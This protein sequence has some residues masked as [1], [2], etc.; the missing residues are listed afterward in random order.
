MTKGF[1]RADHA[2]FVIHDGKIHL[3]EIKTGD[4]PLSPA[5]AKFYPRVPGGDVRIGSSQLADL[6]LPKGHVLK[7]GEI[8]SVRVERWDIDSMPKQLR[9][10]VEDH[11]VFD[12]LDGKAGSGAQAELAKWMHDPATVKIE[13][14]W[15]YGRDGKVHMGENLPFKPE[16]FGKPIRDDLGGPLNA[17]HP[18]ANGHQPL[19]AGHVPSANGGQVGEHGGGVDSGAP[20]GGSGGGTGGTHGGTPPH[21]EQPP[22]VEGDRKLG[23]E[24]INTEKADAIAKNWVEHRF[25]GLTSHEFL[26][27]WTHA[28][29]WDW[30]KVPHEGYVSKTVGGVEVADKFEVE[31]AP[32][33]HID[34]FGQPG[35]GFLSPDATPYEQRAIPPENLV[36][37][38]NTQVHVNDAHPFN[39][40]RYEVVKPFKVDAGVIAPAFEQQGG[41]IQYV[42]N[43][44]YVPGAP[45]RVNVEWL[46][47]HGYLKELPSR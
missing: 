27:K 7:P 26:D 5:Q 34:R 15:W 22:N 32:G 40:Y 35:G 9:S 38:P 1:A 41:G 37:P 29:G 18:E 24:Y 16:E 2:E 11:G 45:E 23:P 10:A 19:D 39:Y 13:K 17:E 25:G 42:L 44:R 3:T 33:T 14:A 20:P 46:L 6:G 4:S 8:P 12:V 31:L 28:D 43:G 21:W 47:D 36:P 30:S